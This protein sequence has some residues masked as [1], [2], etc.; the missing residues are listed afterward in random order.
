M[1]RIISVEGDPFIGLYGIL[2]DKYAIL[3]ENFSDIKLNVPILKTKIY[4]MNF[5]EI[6]CVGNSKGLIVSD[7]ITKDE[8]KKIEN[9]CN[10]NGINF[11]IIENK[12]N[13]I[14]NLISCNDKGCVISEKIS[15]ENI[16]KISE[17][18]DIECKKVKIKDHDEI[19]SMLVVT[20]NGFLAHP[21]AE[22]YIDELK[23][24]FKVDGN[25]GTVNM[26]FP[27]VK[28]GILANSSD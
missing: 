19:G 20:N 6:F 23:E 16:G 3:S 8:R 14:G 21:D 25:V 15:E 17:I 26:G 12:Y 13:A 2:T 7:F 22:N 10:E 28:L 11:G 5:I 4:D 18:L 1:I 9:F 27:Y 24:I